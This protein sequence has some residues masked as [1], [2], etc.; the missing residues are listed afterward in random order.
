M[1]LL[2]NYL[3]LARVHCTLLF[4]NAMNARLLFNAFFFKYYFVFVA[5]D[6]GLGSFVMKQ[7]VFS[8]QTSGMLSLRRKQVLEN[9]HVPCA[10]IC[11]RCVR[12]WHGPQTFS[13]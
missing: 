5:E 11:R 1:E 10:M 8:Y 2:C 13:N 3:I 7:A 9:Q 4:K 6:K 12:F